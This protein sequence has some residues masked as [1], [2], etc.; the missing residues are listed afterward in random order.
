MNEPW[1]DRILRRPSKAEREAFFASLP[2]NEEPFDIEKHCFICG[3]PFGSDQIL[4][5]FKGRLYKYHAECFKFGRGELSKELVIR[6]K[7]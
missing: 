4:D 1:K 2:K 7:E 5:V 3:W 6:V